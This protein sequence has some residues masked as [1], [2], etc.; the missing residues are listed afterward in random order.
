MV[1]LLGT[2]VCVD[3]YGERKNM[4][5]TA[6]CAALRAQLT[7]TSWAQ[8]P[9]LATQLYDTVVH[10]IAEHLVA[11]GRIEIRGFGSFGLR[12]RH[13]H[14]TLNAAQGEVP[15]RNTQWRVHVRPPF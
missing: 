13:A 7:H 5:R 4:T 3:V 2:A 14:A 9:A 11:G 10:T 12:T 6:I 8:D 1:C 15:A